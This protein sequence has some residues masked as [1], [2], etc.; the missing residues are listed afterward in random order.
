MLSVYLS[1]KKRGNSEKNE[2]LEFQKKEIIE[3]G[4][5][6]NEDIALEKER[7]ILRN[8]EALYLAIHRSIENLYSGEGAVVERLTEVHKNLGKACGIDSRLNQETE[9]INSAALQIEDISEKLRA[10]LSNIRIDER[11][12]EEIED[13]IDILN[14]L[15]RKYG[16]TLEF[17]LSSLES[18]D[19]ELSGITNISGEIDETK[20][21]IN[22]LHEALEK[23]AS[24]LSLKRKHAAELFAKK[25]KKELSTLNMHNAAFGISLDSVLSDESTDPFLTIKGSAINETGI[26]RCTFMIAANPGEEPKPLAL[27][28]SGGERSRVILVI[29]AIL[30][31]TESVESIVFDEVDAGIGGGVAEIVGKKLSILAK[32]H[33]VICITHLPQ[34]AKFGDNHFKIS[35]HVVNGKTNVTIDPVG[36]EERIKEIAR[37]LG[38]VNITQATMEHAREMLSGKDDLN[39]QGLEIRGKNEFE[40]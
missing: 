19:R 34:I 38:G 40:P 31:E 10:Y 36:T 37:M 35:K 30:A 9:A 27:I 6:I 32:H 33:Q 20:K 25:V 18:I 11:R 14:K 16:G 1:Q 29:K 7:I 4:V 3:A 8:G 28:A 23:I 39:A 22:R 12:L 15:K 17:V 21:R 13:R 24:E 2:F 5:K 26:D